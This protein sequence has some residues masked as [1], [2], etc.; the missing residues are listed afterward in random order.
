MI[1]IFSV[2]SIFSIISM[3]VVVSIPS[4]SNSVNPLLS[5]FKLIRMSDFP[6]VEAEKIATKRYHP[7]KLGDYVK[8]SKFSNRI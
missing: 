3:N 2:I 1:L 8:I 4:F 6:M 5:N 7:E